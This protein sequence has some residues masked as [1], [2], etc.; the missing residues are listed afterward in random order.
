MKAL[1]LSRKAPAVQYAALAWR[2]AGEGREVLLI[3]SRDTGRWVIAK[4]WPMTGREPWEAA[5]IEAFEEAGVRGEVETTAIGTYRYAKRLP[6]WRER[7]V[8][9]QV[10]CL[11]V[12]EELEDWPERR[13]R[14]RAWFAPGEA[15]AR[16]DEPDLAGIIRGLG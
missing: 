15:A 11:R 7:L 4:G 2:Q 6:R 8:D 10:F 3:T 12:E 9:V 5:A 1:K 16:V 13:Q 14:E